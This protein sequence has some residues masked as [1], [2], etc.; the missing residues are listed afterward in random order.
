MG[1]FN[2]RYREM[3]GMDI[4]AAVARGAEKPFSIE[5]LSLEQPRDDEIVVKIAGVGLCHT[6]LVIRQGF[7]PFPQPAVLGHEGSGEVVAVGAGVTSL[8]PGDH[9]VLSF[10]ACGHCRHCD[11][12]DPAYCEHTGALNYSGAR[13]DGSA[14]LRNGDERVASH[15]FGQSSFASMAIA[16]ERNAIKVDADLPLEL[17]GPLGCGIQ[18][19]AG[20]VINTL[21][22]RAGS[23]LLVTGGGS[24][25]LSA[26][27]AAVAQGCAQIIVSEPQAG[28]RALALELGAT[29]VIDPLAEDVAAAVRA[30]LPGGVD[31]AFDATGMP[32]V[33]G[34]VMGALGVRGTLAIAGVPPAPDAILPVPIL[35]LVSMG[36]TVKGL[37]EGDS[38]PDLFIPQLIAL[39]RAGRFPF[40]KLIKTY[41]LDA[42]NEAIEQ[43]HAGK[44]VKAVLVP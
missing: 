44:C 34:G 35:P 21:A 10:A 8:V 3:I 43:H 16:Y 28:R 37:I 40:D 38:Q 29:H 25:G 18:T 12:A 24:V 15:F 26:V 11:H 31:Y 23:S 33:L 20:A 6:D 13:L 2:D 36:Q 32:Q 1:N 42:I 5:T 7:I 4:K 41:P 19:G 22:C 27:L 9:V 17:L 39:Y 14:A 30:I